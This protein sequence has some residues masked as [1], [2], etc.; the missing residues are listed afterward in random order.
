MGQ[1]SALITGGSAGIG[2]AIAQAL[3]REGWAVTLAA[4]DPDKL[5]AAAASLDASEVNTVAVNLAK[6]DAV[7]VAIGAH[8]D[9]FGGLDLLVNNA[10]MGSVGSIGDKPAKAL[11]LELAINFRSAYLMIQAAIPALRRAAAERGKAHIINVSSLVALVNPPNG[12]VYAA[13]KAA[14]VSLSRSAHAELSRHGIH[15]TALLPGFVDTPGT[16]WTGPSVRDQMLPASDMAE[17]VLFLLRT[18]A[19]CFVPEIIMT[20]A[21]PSIYHSL[22][23][24]D[25]A[26]T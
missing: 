24:W 7:D 14:L 23:D 19:R 16:A 25:S 6:D 9:R 17:A 13:T 1:R 15:V 2:F 26:A 20:N 8:L 21:G 3:V 11:D 18:S 10:G 4:R 12:S 5:A 22:V